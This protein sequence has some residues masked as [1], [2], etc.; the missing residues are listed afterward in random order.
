[1]PRVI[2][3]E[4]VSDD[5][6]RTKKF[7]EEIFGWKVEKWDGP[8]DYWLITTGD[9]SEPGINGAFGRRQSPEDS[10]VNTIGVPDA[11]EYIK[12]IEANGGKIIRPKSA[13][14]GVGW[15]AYCEDTEGNLFGIMQN[16][17]NAK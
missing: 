13:V 7:Y 2:H 15:M 3:F 9:E 14:P 11:D 1:M 17:P 6:E 8:V 4:L 12:K 5:P 10:V 16:D